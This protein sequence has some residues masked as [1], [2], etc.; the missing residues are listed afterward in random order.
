MS[1]QV[2]MWIRLDNSSHSY[3]VDVEPSD[4][5]R[6]VKAKVEEK[7]GIPVNQQQ[8]IFDKVK[9]EDDR[10]LS[11]YKTY[12]NCRLRLLPTKVKIFVTTTTALEVEPWDTIDSIKQKLSDEAQRPKR[13]IFDGKELEDALT[14]EECSFTKESILYSSFSQIR[15]FILT[16]DGKKFPLEVEASETI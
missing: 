14:V 15:I 10:P 16:L 12:K 5:I 8:L 1:L 6:T 3:P 7:E 11:F 4:T 2:K 13:L 9:L